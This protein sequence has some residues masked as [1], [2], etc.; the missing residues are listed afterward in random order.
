MP[1]VVNTNVSS[2]TAQRYLTLNNAQLSKTMEKL[3]S[4]YRINKAGD[5]AAGLYVSENL[6]SQIRGSQ[7]ALDN[8]QDG[9]N[10]LN[11]VDGA[12][13][14]IEDHVQRI[15][16]L[17]VQAGNETYSQNQR[18]AI[19]QEIDALRA[20]IDRIA[21]STQF[22]GTIL[23]SSS[24]ASYS[25][26]IGANATANDALSITTA[27]GDTRA[28]QA[29]GL[30]MVTAASA[31]ITSNATAQTF[32]GVVDAAL[33]ILNGRRATLGAMV[34]RLEGTAKNLM[35]LVE[36]TSA[37][38]SRIRNVDVAA[39]SANMTRYN[40]LQ[41]SSAAVLSQA[42]QTPALALQLLQ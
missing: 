5:D 26:Q 6:R 12:F 11:I 13:Q 33:V 38:E 8:T 36:N 23:L 27:L 7:K 15:R 14:V 35:N 9:I 39:E 25:L 10:V 4:G 41:Q 31:N 3:A 40:I 16:E 17:A 1:L 2:I 32:I 18:T 24:P 22:N 30:N 42:N 37:A 34:N 29:T 28:T 21:A 19:N 20:D